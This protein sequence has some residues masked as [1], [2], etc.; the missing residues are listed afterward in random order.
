M[1][2][3]W[4]HF[5]VFFVISRSVHLLV[6]QISVFCNLCPNSFSISVFLFSVLLLYL[7]GLHI[8][9]VS[10]FK[11]LDGG[12]SLIFLGFFV[13]V[14]QLLVFHFLVSAISVSTCWLLYLLFNIA[15][16]SYLW[17][18]LF[19]VSMVGVLFKC[20]VGGFFLDGVLQSLGRLFGRV[21]GVLFVWVFFVFCCSL[22][23][24]LGCLG[25]YFLGRRFRWVS[26][27]G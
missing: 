24:G 4:F 16:I 20:L 1:V 27:R 21:D 18:F 8:S 3:V 6:F 19:K 23:L 11:I 10:C 12:C 2:G 7:L 26:L 17:C 13:R 5:L 9:G 15:G 14:V 25:L 22:L